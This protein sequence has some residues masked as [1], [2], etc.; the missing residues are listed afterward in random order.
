MELKFITKFNGFTWI[1]RSNRT[2]ME[3]KWVIGAAPLIASPVLIVP[4]WN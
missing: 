2:F 1:Q 4:L 3:L